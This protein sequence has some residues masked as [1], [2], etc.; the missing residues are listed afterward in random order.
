MVL[1]RFSSVVFILT[2]GQIN[3]RTSFCAKRMN[4][5]QMW[6]ISHI[7]ACDRMN[8]AVE[9]PSDPGRDENSVSRTYP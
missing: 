9:G 8:L 4:K 7:S 1:L 5:C 3:I 6:L 2:V